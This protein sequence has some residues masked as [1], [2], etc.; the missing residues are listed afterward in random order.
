[1]V[2]VWQM[3]EIMSYHLTLCMAN[4][5]P[6]HQTLTCK[7]TSHKQV[8]QLTL[9]MNTH[10]NWQLN[11]PTHSTT[12][13]FLELPSFQFSHIH[14]SYAHNTFCTW[15]WQPLTPPARQQRRRRWRGKE[16]WRWGGQPPPSW[17]QRHETYVETGPLAAG[18]VGACKDLTPPSCVHK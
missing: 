17:G 13:E 1:M 16:E 2:W 7:C 12:I 15:L 5:T 8:R 4:Q 9:G 11:G 3:M 6:T 14:I 10:S 18:A